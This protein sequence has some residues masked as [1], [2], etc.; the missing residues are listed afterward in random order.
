[1]L[2][3]LR[4]NRPMQL[5]SFQLNDKGFRVSFASW[6]LYLPFMALVMPD[7][8]TA[9]LQWMDV[10]TGRF[11][12]AVSTGVGI[13]I[14]MDVILN[15]RLNR[16][17]WVTKYRSHLYVLGAFVALVIP[18]AVGKLTGISEFGAFFYGLVAVKGIWLFWVNERAIRRA[19]HAR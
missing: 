4:S 17:G 7:T 5:S 2:A 13:A 12:L 19:R 10:A 9:A 18:F 1:M 3:L 14:V 6:M 8:L 16:W 15:W 11:V